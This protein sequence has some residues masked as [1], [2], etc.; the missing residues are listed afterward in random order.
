MDSLLEMFVHVDDFCQAFQPNLE[1]HLLGS[2][3]V[4]RHRE[5]SLSVSE[6]MTI[7]IHVHQSHYRN[8]KAYYCEHVLCICAVSFP[9]W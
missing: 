9:I 8:I 7:L 4:K 1:Q 2:G 3:T 5:R 6:V